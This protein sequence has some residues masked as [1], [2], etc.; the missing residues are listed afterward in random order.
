MCFPLLSFLQ[1]S[2]S[3]AEVLSWLVNL[4]TAGTL[5]DYI[6]MSVTYLFFYRACKAQGVNRS[7]FPYVGWFQPW[8]GYIGAIF[9][10][11]VLVF[12]GY[13]SFSPWSIKDFFIYYSLAGLSPILYFGWKIIK[14]TSIIKPADADLIWDKP[15]FDAYEE[16]TT[17]PVTGFWH[18]MVQLVNFTRWGKKHVVDSD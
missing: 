4:I 10:A 11:T 9:M 13:S 8:S 6:V 18:D 7:Q 14:K 5:I 3:T 15:I 16:A 17:E 2:N 12:Y 1:V